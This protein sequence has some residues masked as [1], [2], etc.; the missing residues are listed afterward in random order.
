MT[1]LGE[2]RRGEGNDT[3]MERVLFRR[4]ERALRFSRS[5]AAYVT[6]FCLHRQPSSSP[7]TLPWVRR[8]ARLRAW[9]LAAATRWCCQHS[10]LCALNI[11]TQR[12]AWWT[13]L[14]TRVVRSFLRKRCYTARC[15]DVATVASSVYRDH[16]S[17]LDVALCA[18]VERAV[19]SATWFAP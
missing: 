6:F 1:V 16:L 4:T 2:K 10:L 12:A 8:Y 18:D 15:G 9:L 13:R 5:H 17:S 3:C 11:T 7:V 19:A 14:T